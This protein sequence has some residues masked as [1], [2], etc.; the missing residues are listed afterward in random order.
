MSPSSCHVL[1]KTHSLIQMI[2]LTPCVMVTQPIATYLP[3]PTV[4][5]ISSSRF[6]SQVHRHLHDLRSSMTFFLFINAYVNNSHIK[7]QGS[8]RPIKRLQLLKKYLQLKKQSQE[9][10]KQNK[11]E[12][13]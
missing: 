11:N 4:E 13:I 7:R 9:D 2:D 6:K 3:E 5:T 1:T 10:K 12:N 8:E